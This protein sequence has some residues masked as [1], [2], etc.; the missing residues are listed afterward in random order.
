MRKASKAAAKTASG[1]TLVEL[2]V[3]IAIIGVLVA[4][5]LPAVQAAREAARRMSCS[6]N[7]KNLGLAVQNYASSHKTF[8]LSTPYRGTSA[9][10][11]EG[12]LVVNYDSQTVEYVGPNA[13]A[14]LDQTGR[15]GK[16]WITE[17]LPYLEQ[18]PLYDRFKAA[19]AFDGHFELARGMRRNNPEVRAGMATILPV[20]TCPSDPSA[21]QTSTDQWWWDNIP[22]ALTSYKGVLG[23]SAVLESTTRWNSDWGSTPDCHDKTGCNGILWRTNYFDRPSLKMVTD[24]TSNTLI[25]GETVAE[26][27]YHAAAY[28]S[29]GDWASCNVQL[30]FSPD[31][32]ALADSEWVKDFWYDVRGFRSRHPGGVTFAMVD[33]S[34]QFINEGIDHGVYRALSTKQGAE[35]ASLP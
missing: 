18:Q 24:G 8:P 4:L 28:F 23:D 20:L 22:V 3:V 34:V 32:E 21:G 6:N 5:L 19:G 25:I 10:S 35:T 7:V 15:T 11:C 17:L 2:L 1:F 16:G 33:A 29:D 9:N 13:C 12:N 30:N 26:L 14:A 31:A 27:D